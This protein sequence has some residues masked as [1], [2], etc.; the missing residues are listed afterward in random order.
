MT[1]TPPYPAYPA[2]ELERLTSDDAGH[3]HTAMAHLYRGEMHRMA[4]WRQRLDSTTGW[5]IVLVLGV[6]TFAL[7][8]NQ[9]PPYILLLGLASVGMCL[10]I[11]ARRYQHVH[12]S[13]CRL[14]AYERYYFGQVLVPP[15]GPEAKTWRARLA[16][17]LA[18][19]RRTISLLGAI[20]FRLRRHYAMLLYF[21]TAAWLAKV[22]IHPS[23]PASATEFYGRL[24]V[25]GL[26]PS[27]FVAVTA[28]TFIL[29]A[30]LLALFSKSEDAIECEGLIDPDDDRVSRGA[31]SCRPDRARVE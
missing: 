6:T 16:H 5:A 12:R 28:T 29:T 23:S 17:E 31:A 11:E 19:P 26:F 14:R 21:I 7:G 10:V 27:W 25:G 24:A 9:T 20:Q 3:F 18:H 2:A 30:T 15:S 4:M 1:N 22:F 13:I 8:A